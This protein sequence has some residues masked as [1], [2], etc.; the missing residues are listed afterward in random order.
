MS[1]NFLKR[2]LKQN[3]E[4]L[5][6]YVQWGVS[7]AQLVV[8]PVSKLLRH[9]LEVQDI[10]PNTAAGVKIREAFQEALNA[11]VDIKHRKDYD[12]S[13]DFSQSVKDSTD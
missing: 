12:D 3:P 10:D 2:Y 4:T 6:S 1:D 9:L 7:A 11:A 5:K 8:A 13:F